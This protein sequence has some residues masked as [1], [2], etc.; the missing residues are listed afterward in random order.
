VSPRVDVRDLLALPTWTVFDADPDG[1]VLA[2]WDGPGSVQLVELGTDGS[3]TQLTAL[4]GACSG[5]YVVGERAVVVEH[6]TDGDERAQLSVLPLDPRPG[7]PASLDDLVPLVR[8]PA[9]I[10]TLVDLLPGHVVYSTNRR[11]GVDFDVVV[12]ALGPEPAE[13]TLYD[14]GGYVAAASAD[15]RRCAVTLLSL[16]PCSTQVLL[17]DEGGTTPVTDADEHALHEGA[18]LL[19]DGGLVLSSNSGRDL[20]AVVRVAPDGTRTSL[21]AADEHD[22][23]ATV[24]PDGRSMLV[25]TSVD[26]GHAVAMHDLD[27][28][29]RYEVPLSAHGVATAVW[30]ADSHWVA[31]WLVAPTR[32]GDVLLLDAATGDLRVLVD[33]N[34]AVSAHIAEALVEPS[35]H[36]VPA[37]DGEQIPCFVYRP[38]EPVDGLAGSVVI[39]VH[40]GPEAQARRI[41]NPV[42]QALVSAGHTV[43]V[44]NVRGSTGYG[45]RWYSLDDVRLRLESVAD[46]GDLRAW[47]D[48]VDGDPERVALYG[49]SYGGY[50]VLA[51]LSMQPELWAAGVDI[52]GIS[53]LVTFLENTSA[54]RR[55]VRERE[56]GRLDTDRDFLVAASPLTHLDDLAAPLFVI[57]GANDPRVPLSES[58]QIKAALDAKGIPC[59]L[60]VYADEGH[61]LAKRANRLDAYP[62]VLEFLAER[63]REKSDR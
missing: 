63:L 29:R 12:R 36:R 50:L 20:T 17:S 9:A 10:H 27:G 15:A 13:R 14:R 6:D 30:S 40:G 51:G 60:L 46:L 2:G 52:V 35:S 24:S 28:T 42:V 53:S 54:Y 58:E 7:Q 59:T 8:D 11:N 41:F 45:K 61:G 1:R 26:G 39:N 55:A 21:V 34:E 22:L 62:R 19:S 32:P 18:H 16:Q 25:L 38:A 47:V 37:R 56:Y 5:R 23:S 57:H 49:G 3:R 44:P 4:P 43:L 33:G 31:I 48:E